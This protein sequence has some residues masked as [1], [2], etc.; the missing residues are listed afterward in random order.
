[1]CSLPLAPPGKPVKEAGDLL[2]VPSSFLLPRD[3]GVGKARFRLF[4]MLSVAVEFT[5]VNGT[6]VE[7]AV[8]SSELRP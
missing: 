2:P 7:V 8:A 5:V 3:P 4:L 1:M 6:L